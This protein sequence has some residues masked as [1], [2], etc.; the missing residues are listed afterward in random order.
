M[1]VAFTQN[2]EIVE[3]PL[4]DKFPMMGILF[5][6]FFNFYNS[7]ELLGIEIT[8]FLPDDFNQRTVVY[9]R[10]SFESF[11][12]IK[13][14]LTRPRELHQYFIYDFQVLF[15]QKFI[16]LHSAIFA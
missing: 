3:G 4:Y 1:L 2:K 8:P 12:Q 5:V 13:G 6:D 11:I 16:G 15:D 10:K 14:A 7:F 9:F